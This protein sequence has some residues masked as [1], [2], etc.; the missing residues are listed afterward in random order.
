M[1]ILFN[2]DPKFVG[3]LRDSVAADRK[4]KIILVAEQPG[5]V[6]SN[7][8]AQRIDT[9]LKR[10]RKELFSAFAPPTPCQIT[11]IVNGAD[12]GSLARLLCFCL[13][14]SKLIHCQIF[15][16]RRVGGKLQLVSCM[17]ESISPPPTHSAW[18]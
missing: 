4:E 15:E 11:I 7:M 6:L 14:A 5:C 2:G 13:Q 8:K 16:L 18:L 3:M 10:L 9:L 17:T 12:G 1:L